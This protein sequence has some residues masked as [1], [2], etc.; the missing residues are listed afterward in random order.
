MVT[1]PSLSTLPSTEVFF[2]FFFGLIFQIILYGSHHTA[3]SFSEKPLDPT[4]PFFSSDPSFK[5]HFVPCAQLICLFN[6]PVQPTY[7]S[8]DQIGSFLLGL[9]LIHFVLRPAHFAHFSVL[10]VFYRSYK[11]SLSHIMDSDSIC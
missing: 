9:P 10:S 1:C 6:P 11:S 2:S 3:H 5:I 4:R 7:R 8:F